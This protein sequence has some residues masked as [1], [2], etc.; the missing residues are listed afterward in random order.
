M[1]SY[2]QCQG[3]KD[4]TGKITAMKLID[5]IRETRL[6]NTVIGSIK[7]LYYSVLRR[8]YGF[9][10]WSVSPFELR[11]YIQDVAKYI[12]RTESDS[13]LDI[14]C[15]LGELLRHVKATDKTGYD[16]DDKSIAVAKR[17]DRKHSITFN[18]GS[19]EEARGYNVDVMVSL[20]FMHERPAEY[21]KPIYK[22][23][24]D[25][26]QIKTIILDSV[27]DNDM[28]NHIEWRKVLPDIYKPVETMGP[29]KSGRYIHIFSRETVG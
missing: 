4:N 19:F 29:Y 6:R 22:K 1:R 8:K 12:N 23:M 18:T 15:G 17:L 5:K 27:P 28:Q 25:Q 20:N 10:K 21:W 2:I 7:M 26:N 24:T 3:Q 14:G 11:P 16:I 9:F 13:V